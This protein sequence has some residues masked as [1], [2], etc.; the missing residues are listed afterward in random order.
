MD[1]SGKKLNLEI[2]VLQRPPLDVE[3]IIFSHKFC[4]DYIRRFAS[5]HP[6]RLVNADHLRRVQDVL[7]FSTADIL[8]IIDENELILPP[9]AYQVLPQSVYTKDW[10]AMVPVYNAAQNPSQRVDLSRYIYHNVR[11][12]IE[13]T[14]KLW[15][16]AEQTIRRANSSTEWPCIFVRREMLRQE[17]SDMPLK[18]VWSLW[19]SL[20]KIGQV[21]AL[22]AHRF[23]GYYS[24]PRTDLIDL[25]PDS[26]ETVLDV[27]CA[28][29]SLGKALKETRHC[30]ITG[31]ELNPVMADVAS[32][33]YDKVY[34]LPVEDISF[35][36]QFDAIICGDVI[37][38]LRDPEC[39][40]SHLAQSLTPEGILIG[41]V[42]NT[43][44]WSIVMDLAQGRFEMIPVGLL[45]MSH[46][47]FFTEIELRNLLRS[48]GLEIDLMHRDCPVP[49]P[50][51]E[52][53]IST[54]ISAGMGDE[55]SLRTSEL[56]FRAHKA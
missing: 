44:H 30:H 48:S 49:T 53:F 19:A 54:L 21:D 24:S 38:H 41:T 51:G 2:L 20:G 1:I 23:S 26:A 16:S 22:F 27:G 13:V 47:R 40:L 34:N 17:D 32:R 5:P 14:E 3:E 7:E 56:R 45:C 31:I 55:V 8:V 42:P 25:I 52:R 36:S 15:Q 10:A 46:I 6:V 37:E 11:N 12:F 33:I 28:R 18:D 29:G 35:K 39:V 4:L 50:D 43:G 9:L